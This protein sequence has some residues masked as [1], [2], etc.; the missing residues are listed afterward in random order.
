MRRS[1]V[2]KILQDQCFC[3]QRDCNKKCRKCDLYCPE[4][5]LIEAL[6]FAI[7]A[8]NNQNKLKKEFFRSGIEYAKAVFVRILE[9]EKDN[10]GKQHKTK[11]V[12][13]LKYIQVL[14]L[15]K[16][17]ELT[18]GIDSEEATKRE[19]LRVDR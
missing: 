6:S 1:D 16:A 5:D 12:D 4:E 17:I 15:Q 8:L 7:S 10:V 18:E 9:N 2:I 14:G 3:L 19:T 11:E 13:D